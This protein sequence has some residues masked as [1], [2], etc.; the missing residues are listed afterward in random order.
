MRILQGTI[1][2]EWQR[3]LLEIV[4][5]DSNLEIVGTASDAV[6]L[7]MQTEQLDANVVVLSQ[8]P[9]GGE[10]GVC[11]H[12]LLEYPN[13][14]VLLLPGNDGHEVLC[15]M[16]LSKESWQHASKETLRAALKT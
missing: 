13:V 3:A 10:P 4:Q 16:V 5:A 2:A 14:A 12:L 8:L 1:S 6:D 9:D 7:L 11:S 15:R